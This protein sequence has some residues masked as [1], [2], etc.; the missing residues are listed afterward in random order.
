[1]ADDNGASNAHWLYQRCSKARATMQTPLTT[2]Q[3]SLRILHVV[4]MKSSAN[5]SNGGDSSDDDSIDEHAIQQQLFEATKEG[6]KRDI[7]F[8]YEV[9]ERVEELMEDE[10]LTVEALRA[11]AARDVD[12]GE[13]VRE[14]DDA[15]EQDG[16]NAGTTT[17]SNGTDAMDEGSKEDADTPQIN[18]P[19]ST[20][21]SINNAITIEDKLTQLINHDE[22][23]C[24]QIRARIWGLMQPTFT[25]ELWKYLQMAGWT[26]TLGQYHIPK[27]KMRRRI[28]GG[29]DS[30]SIDKG[31][32][33]ICD[34]ETIA[35]RIYEEFD[36]DREL[37]RHDCE[38]VP[39]DHD[40]DGEQEE[41]PEIFASPNDLVEY[42]D[43]YCMP[44]YSATPAEVQKQ[45][46]LLAKKSKAYERRARRLRYDV[47]EIA[48][49]ERLRHNI[50]RED[51]DSASKYGHNHRPCDVCFEGA[52]AL[53]PRVACRDCGLV[54]HTKCY[55]LL[56]YGEKDV[57]SNFKRQE[58]DEKGY[59]TC[60]VCANC[61]PGSK[62]NKSKVWNATQASGWRVHNH[63]N[64]ICPLCDGATI[65]GGMVRLVQD[66]DKKESA[67]PAQ[68]RGGRSGRGSNDASAE[69]WVHL[70]CL[71]SLPGAKAAATA[72]A[73]GSKAIEKII[74]E[75]PADVS[76][77]L[78][79]GRCSC[80]KGRLLQCKG[81]CEE[82]YHSICIQLS[83]VDGGD[84]KSKDHICS[85]CKPGD[86]ESSSRQ[87][88][89]ATS[90]MHKPPPSIEVTAANIKDEGVDQYFTKSRKK[91]ANSMDIDRAIVIPTVNEC[92][93]EAEKAYEQSDLDAEFD[94]FEMQYR[95][96]F[97]K[98]AISLSSNQSILLYG[99]GS[100]RS[101][102]DD[103]GA[104]L[105][106]EGD[107]ISLNGYDTDVDMSEFI[108]L[109]EQLFVDNDSGQ[110]N[111]LVGTEV[112]SLHRDSGKGLTKRASHV[113]KNFAATRSRPLFLLIHNIDGAS[114]RNRFAQDALAT[115]TSDSKRDGTQLIRVVAS[116]DNVNVAM[117]LWDP[118]IQHKFDWS[119]KRVHTHRAY[120][121]EIRHGPRTESTK[122]A[123]KIH[124]ERASVVAVAKVLESLAPRHAEVVQLLA[125]LQRSRNSE[126]VSF[127][128]LKSQCASKMLTS[129]DSQLRNMLKELSDHGIVSVRTDEETAKQIVC[130]PHKD[131][132]QEIFD[133][134]YSRRK[135]QH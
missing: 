132:V 108:G 54:V 22:M 114:L 56:D 63:P 127:A 130:I 95:D 53:H 35:R 87:D 74:K 86:A 59:F 119:L 46:D 101:V 116:V 96:Q 135:Q 23:Y 11:I 45:K 27:K 20:T 37:V 66:G 61:L 21:N 94:R 19:Q 5:N 110:T 18:K 26:Y 38:G 125:T 120:F 44:D 24:F 84:V 13:A 109:M 115:L 58:V 124:I 77:E 70:F 7:S 64:A 89:V 134:R 6:K 72:L 33:M 129:S 67:K 97:Y 128:T 8:V 102:L 3:L 80:K 81:S 118:I 68:K 50:L 47:L 40:G 82:Y 14:T 41:G 49:R 51:V 92:V 111:A 75:V 60:H 31:K 73:N 12:C 131:M 29:E 83:R 16:T 121:E 113:A 76:D 93:A 30:R 98:W 48:F 117:F 88:E 52:N 105:S 62:V 104:S 106:S 107:V 103:F 1:M 10:D 9:V 43:Q 79:C 34:P 90:Y 122:K 42:L 65:A 4:K 126:P 112:E 25:S 55:G 39:N 133:F 71:E 2:L 36:L 99:L 17:S 100:K 28:G 78:R 57:G 123:R 69:T 15:V 85:K 32:R 91:N